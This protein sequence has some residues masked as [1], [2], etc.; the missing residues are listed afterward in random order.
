MRALV[1]YKGFQV[2]SVQTFLLNKKWIFKTCQ[3]HHIKKFSFRSLPIAP[4]HHCSWARWYV[5]KTK[6][7]LI[8]KSKYCSFLNEFVFLEVEKKKGSPFRNINLYSSPLN[9]MLWTI[10]GLN[11]MGPLIHRFF[12]LFSINT[13]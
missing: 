11:Y 8:S 12:L 4:N 13:L 5:F 2:I 6:S 10:T 7:T 9:N 1:N 3:N